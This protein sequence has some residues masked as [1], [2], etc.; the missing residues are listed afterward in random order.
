MSTCKNLVTVDLNLGS[1]ALGILA[2]SYKA[3]E[4][5]QSHMNSA[6]EFSKALFRWRIEGQLV[7]LL[8]G[9][10]DGHVVHQQGRG[11]HRGRHVAGDVQDKQ[12]LARGLYAGA[13]GA[14]VQ[15]AES[16]SAHQSALALRADAIKQSRAIRL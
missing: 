12:I 4:V 14:L 15:I 2:D 11:Q 5:L 13:Q 3:A 6:P 7:V 8:V 10:F 16:G 1:E 9:A